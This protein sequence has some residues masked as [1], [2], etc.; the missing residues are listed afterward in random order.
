VTDLLENHSAEATAVQHVDVLIVGAGI[1]GIGA[2]YH[3]LR[4]HPQRTFLMLETLDHF[5]GT[6]WTH[7]YPGIRS[8]SDLYTFGYKFKPWTG[9]PIA[10]AEEIMKYLTEVVEENGI[11]QHIRYGHRIDAASWSSDDRLWTIHAT[12]LETGE[13]L[14]FTANFFWMCGGY[15]RHAQGYTPEWEGMEN[16]GGT[17]VHP[18]TWPDDL[19]LTDKNVVVIGSGATAATLIPNVAYDCKHVTM[20]QRSPTFFFSRPNRNELAD[21]L[22][23]LEIPEEWIHEI[24]R[25][26]IL[27]DGEAIIKMSFDDP[28]ALRSA[29]VEGVREL[30]PEGFDVD[31]HFNPPYRPWQQ[32]IALLPDGDL[33]KAVR[34][35]QASVA[36]DQ[37]DHFTE[38]GIAL[39]SGEHLDADV[40]ITATGFTMS[41]MGDIRYMVDGKI[42]NPA[43]LVTYR[44]VMFT[45]MPNFAYVFGYFRSSWTLR[46]DMIS[47]F[48]SRMLSYMDEHGTD[49]VQ[50]VL[51]PGDAEMEL[52]DWVE[53]DQFN[54]G[55]L[56][57]SMHLLPKQGK[58]DPWRLHHDYRPE[59]EMF[60]A[61]KF[62]DEPLMFK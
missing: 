25:R 21:T 12:R 35:G 13:E 15:Y 39:T 24:V 17:I 6:W 14:Q 2:A 56:A 8:D 34:D 9:A 16:F 46:A 51:P 57:R 59:R 23:E 30:L 47:E 19:D 45:D 58:Y 31:R 28:D 5:G 11:D 52:C 3:L 44:G 62:D 26:R 22:R 43:E 10:T 53:Q 60:E 54:P 37:I 41:V 7:K 33:F 1:S 36:T 49:M 50:P 32:R 48:V 4:D 27:T 40:I 18:Q 55:Y 38:T 61:V 42:I 29:L 20:L